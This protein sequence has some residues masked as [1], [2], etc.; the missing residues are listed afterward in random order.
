MGLTSFEDIIKEKLKERKNAHFMLVDGM[1][2][3]LTQKV[4]YCQSLDF[5]VSGIRWKLLIR[6]ALGFNDCLSYSVWIIDEKYTGSYWEVKFNFKIGIVPQTGSDYC[7]V[8]VGC[9]NKQSLVL[10][11]DN[12]IS[13]T[14]LKERFLV[15]DKAVFYA[16]ISD[17]QP[18]FPV[19]GIP[20]TM[21]TAERLKLIEVAR[22][23][24]RFTWKITKFSS[25][26][27][28]EHSSYEFTVGPRR[29]RLSMYPKGSGD[30]KGNSLSL[31]LTASD[32]VTDGP[33]GG[34]LAIYKL[35][36]LDQLHRNHYE[37]N[38][39]DWF[40]HLTTWGR[41]K[42]L[43]LEELHKASRGFLVNDQIYI[44]VEFLIVSTTEYL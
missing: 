26:T 30:G 14:V 3:L 5:Q 43:P 10:G 12:F 18:N 25:F 32:Y 41:N 42:F 35:R 36:V 6:P 38:C 21:G 40:L 1:S 4:K 23:N 27:G 20:R 8:F 31:Y 7:Y 39:E 16:E 28:V 17:V 24:S 15:N 9:H 13:Y 2:K 19:T 44:G 34:T 11:L 37:I 29:W 22:N 33:K